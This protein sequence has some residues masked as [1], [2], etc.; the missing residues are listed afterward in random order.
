MIIFTYKMINNLRAM[1]MKVNR[2][3]GR[4]PA[5]KIGIT[6]F[7]KIFMNMLEFLTIKMKYFRTCK[8]LQKWNYF[9]MYFNITYN[10]INKINNRLIHSNKQEIFSFNMQI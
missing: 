1:N 4:N 6:M 7:M 10:K 5:R 9:L 2:N 8:I 3:N